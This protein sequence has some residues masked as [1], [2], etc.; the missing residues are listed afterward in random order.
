MN[1][2]DLEHLSDDELILFNDLLKIDRLTSEEII[3]GKLD[4]YEDVLRKLDISCGANMQFFRRDIQGF[5]SVLMESKYAERKKTQKK[6]KDLIKQEDDSLKNIIAALDN[7]QQ[8]IK[9]QLNSYFGATANAYFRWFDNRLA[10]AITL[11]GQLAI[12]WVAKDINQYVNKLCGT[13]DIDYIAAIDTDSIYLSLDTLVN[14]F[15]KDE[16]DK[17]KIT[18]MINKIAEEKIQPLIEESCKRMAEHMNAYD[19]RLKMGRELIADSMIV[20]AK[21]RYIVNVYDKEGVVKQEPELK[22]TGIEAVRSSTPGLCREEIINTLKVVMNKTESDYQDYVAD[23]RE[24]FRNA[25]FEQIAFPRGVSNVGGK[26]NGIDFEK[27]TV[28]HAKGAQ[29]YNYLVEKKGLRDKY[30]LIGNGDKIK[31]CYLKQPNPYGSNVIAAPDNLPKEFGLDDFLDRDTQFEKSF[32]QPIENITRC[33]GWE[34]EKRSTL[35]DFFG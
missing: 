7:R 24:K 32:L 21:K 4:L 19:Q 14:K 25:S 8:A 10:E 9:I 35:N 27:G 33:I 2:I 6:M 13:K 18:R 23:F 26:Y 12:K 30:E 17:H 20:V 34:A 3:E 31:F 28:I 29:L 5:A 22:V 1:F 16:T 15:F 11:S